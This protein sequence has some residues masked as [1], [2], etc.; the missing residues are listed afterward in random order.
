M[1]PVQPLAGRQGPVLHAPFLTENRTFSREARDS[2]KSDDLFQ[3]G[4]PP[5]DLLRLF[6]LRQVATC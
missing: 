1:T 6:A 2:D 4:S 5:P 3:E